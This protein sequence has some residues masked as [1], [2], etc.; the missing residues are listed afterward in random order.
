MT[1]QTPTTNPT[2][3]CQICGRSQKV[4]RGVIAHHGYQQPWRTQGSGART[5][6]CPGSRHL[7]YEVSRDAIPAVRAN[8]EAQRDSCRAGA[9]ELATNPPATFSIAK[10]FAGYPTGE[11]ITLERP[12]DFDAER[13][14]RAGAYRLMCYEGEHAARLRTLRNN[15]KLLQDGVEFLTARY[16]EWQPKGVA[17]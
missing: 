15:A 5:A 7:P 14:Y 16:D 8:Y 6:S 3:T 13:N 17:A 4:V 12:A 9:K 10:K 2:G 11:T 1:D